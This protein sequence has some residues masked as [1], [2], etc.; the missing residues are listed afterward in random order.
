V[1]ISLTVRVPDDT[2][3]DASITVATSAN[4]WTHAPLTREPG[5]LVATGTI[6]VPR[7]RWFEYKFARGGWSTAERYADCSEARNRYGF[8]AAFPARH[9]TVW[10]WSDRC[11]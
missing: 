4:G 9:D 2:P 7:G 10:R 3:R 6:T 8:G 1:R 11:P 5:A